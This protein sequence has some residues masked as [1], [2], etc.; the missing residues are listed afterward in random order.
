MA[1]RMAWH[2]NRLKAE[3]HRGEPME[4]MEG[5]HLMEK[6]QYLTKKARAFLAGNDVP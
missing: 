6:S 4:K 3:A 2:Q 1:D 5:P